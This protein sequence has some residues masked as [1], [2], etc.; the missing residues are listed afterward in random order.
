MYCLAAHTWCRRLRRRNPSKHH[1]CL[2][3]GGTI[4]ACT[5]EGVGFCDASAK[6]DGYRYAVSLQQG[7]AHTGCARSGVRVQLLWLPRL[8]TNVVD[9]HVLVRLAGENIPAAAGCAAPW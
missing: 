5:S 1:C 4:E 8:R 9:E 3:Q 2:Q 6:P 7:T